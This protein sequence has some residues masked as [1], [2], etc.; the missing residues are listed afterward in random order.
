M[1]DRYVFAPVPV[2]RTGSTVRLRGD[3]PS[4]WT[5]WLVVAR[6]RSKEMARWGTLPGAYIMSGGKPRHIGG[7]TIDTM[8]QL[9][10]DYSREGDL[11]ADPCM[12]AGTTGLACLEMGRC[13]VGWE[14]ERRTFELAKA[15]LELA[16]AGPSSP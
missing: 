3:G 5:T 12:G 2:V 6:P 9:V 10:R 15:S 11:V 14:R 7:K 8:R 4:N 13:F 16:C 1:I